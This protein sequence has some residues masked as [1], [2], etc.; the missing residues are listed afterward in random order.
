MQRFAAKSSTLTTKAVPKRYLA[1]PGNQARD[2]GHW[3]CF[4]ALDMPYAQ[5]RTPVYRQPC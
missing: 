1:K 3:L 4:S 2:A 5:E